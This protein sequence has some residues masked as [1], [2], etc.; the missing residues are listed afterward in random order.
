MMGS[1]S[2]AL[3]N[4]PTTIERMPSSASS[5]PVPAPAS[6]IAKAATSLNIPDTISCTPNSTAIT[7]SVTFGQTSVAIPRGQG[8]DAVGQHPAPVP[9]EA[10]EQMS[11][12]LH[13]IGHGH[14]SSV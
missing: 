13:H 5:T 1:R 2:P 6:S 11:G 7:S 8:D 9:A 3:D 14:P 10:S 12:L 4:M